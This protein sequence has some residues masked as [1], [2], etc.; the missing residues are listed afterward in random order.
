MI[1]IVAMCSFLVTNAY[2]LNLPQTNLPESL[3]EQKKGNEFLQIIWNTDRV[4][5]DVETQVYL[6]KIGHELSTFSEDPSKHFD[7]LM[8]DDN[9]INA[10]AGPYGYIGVHTGML[11]SSESEA[12]LAGVLSHEMSHVTQNHLS[13]FSEKT[14]KQTYIMVAG[15]IAAALV[16]NTNASQAIAAST[17]AGTAQQ[18][19]NF[20]R[21]HEWEADRIG[22]NMLSKTGFDPSGMAHFFEKLKDDPNAQE[23]LR[24]HPLSINRVSDAMQRSSRLT[25]DYRED[26]FE[27]QTIKAKLYYHQNKRIKLNKDLSVTLYMQA[28]E[29]LEAQKYI[30]AKSYIDQLLEKNQSEPS[31]ILAGRVYSKLGQLEI[32][33]QHFSKVLQTESGVY[34]AA[35]A[36]L[37]NRQTQKGIQLL[38]RY[39]KQNSGTYQ[40]HKLLSSLYVDTGSLDRAHIHN[41]KALVTQGKLDQAIDR[42]ERAKSTT[43]SQDLFDVINVEIERL[44]KRIDLYKELL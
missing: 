23:F 10:F 1:K 11:L 13:R 4:V 44:E 31:Y 26:S 18:N 25:G 37:E 2:A 15:M 27:Y 29:A 33:Q 34:Y 19:I 9:S 32:A 28:Y 42:Y 22:T 5:G 8:L 7:F 39:L 36:Y 30:L 6:K 12:E 21:E 14:D 35:Q 43:R 16:D 38:R 41:A 3:Q 24:S 20:T 17:V 40:S